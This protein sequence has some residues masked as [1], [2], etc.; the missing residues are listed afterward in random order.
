MT[1]GRRT[2]TPTTEAGKQTK[3]ERR[4]C[5]VTTTTTKLLKLDDAVVNIAK[6]RNPLPVIEFISDVVG[7]HL[8]PVRRAHIIP[9]SIN[10]GAASSLHK[11]HNIRTTLGLCPGRSVLRSSAHSIRQ[12]LS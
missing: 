10:A 11:A 4:A 3:T 8:H 5:A 2:K 6:L 1:L 12:S 9:E 7:R